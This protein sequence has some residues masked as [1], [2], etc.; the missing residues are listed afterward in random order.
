MGHSFF[1][2]MFNEFPSLVENV[3]IRN[4]RQDV[5]FA[6]G[7]SGLPSSLWNGIT[8]Y[9]EISQEMPDRIKYSL[10]SGP[11]FYGMVNDLDNVNRKASND[12]LPN[13]LEYYRKWFD[14]ALQFN[15]NITFMIGSWWQG[16]IIENNTTHYEDT[17]TIANIMLNDVKTLRRYYPNNRIIGVPYGLG[18]ADI[19]FIFSG[20]VPK[21]RI[22]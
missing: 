5:F 9:S 15:K 22:S 3:G 17:T 6:G 7:F 1:A 11:D 10:Y 20:F 19:S 18:V 14:Y 13:G 8:N 12:N 16:Q 2:W 21:P 4:H